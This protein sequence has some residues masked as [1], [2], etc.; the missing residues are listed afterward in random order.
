[1]SENA[2]IEYLKLK[3]EEWTRFH[4]ESDAKADKLSKECGVLEARLELAEYRLEVA[5]RKYAQLSGD[6][7]PEWPKLSVWETIQAYK[8]KPK[9][10]L[11]IPVRKEGIPENDEIVELFKQSSNQFEND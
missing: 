6:Y 1:M 8:E 2:E 9:Y 3:V 4:K 7:T 11:P 10:V 5:R